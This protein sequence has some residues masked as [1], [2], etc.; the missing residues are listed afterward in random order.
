M[1][2]MH[3]TITAAVDAEVLMQWTEHRDTEKLPLAARAA[4]RTC[5]IR[6]WLMSDLSAHRSHLGLQS[7]DWLANETEAPLRTSEH[8]DSR[9]YWWFVWA[10][11]ICYAQVYVGIHFPLDVTC[12]A[13]IG[14]ILG[15]IIAKIF[16]QKIGLTTVV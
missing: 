9:G 1:A 5:S 11:T 16:N 14:L 4:L 3:H 8:L 13:I 2:N 15:Y 10:A 7:L 12:G 6:D